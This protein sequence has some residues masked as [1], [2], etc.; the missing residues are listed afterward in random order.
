MAQ[1]DITKGQLG[2]ACKN[3]VSGIK[4]IYIA[5]YDEYNYLTSSTSA[6][7]ILTDLGDLTEVFKF[8]L[9]NSGNTFNQEINSNRDNGTTLFNQVMTFVLTKLNKEMEFQVKLMAWGR[10]QIFVEMNSGQVF[11][12]GIE[13]G[14]EITGNGAVGGTL[15]SL[16]GYTLTATATEPAPIYYLEAATITALKVLISTENIEN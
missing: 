2:L 10:P 1:C 3:T 9:K 16:N 11:L 14:C 5:N 6:G 15:D 4:A 8:D 13:N 7:H 12:M